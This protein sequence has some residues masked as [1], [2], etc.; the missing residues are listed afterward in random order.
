MAEFLLIL[1]KL[2]NRFH[3]FRFIIINFISIFFY[4]G[5]FGTVFKCREKGSKLTLAA[6]FI[7]IERRQDR[8]NV[9]REVEIMRTLQHPRLIQLYDAFEADNIMCVILEL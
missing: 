1:E 3:T 7:P 2:A 9:E 4:R 6:K 5:K 8:K